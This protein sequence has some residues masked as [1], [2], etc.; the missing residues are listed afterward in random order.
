M[1]YFPIPITFSFIKQQFQKKKTVLFL[2]STPFLLCSFPPLRF[3]KAISRWSNST[4]SPIL[5]SSTF[6]NLSLFPPCYLY[7]S[8]PLLRPLVCSRSIPPIHFLRSIPSISS[9]LHFPPCL[10]I[11]FSHPLS[12]LL[13]FLLLFLLFSC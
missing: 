3:L 2:S 5:N 7:R 11:F 1:L 9:P 4:L 10:W 6:R 13:N 12:P 8:I